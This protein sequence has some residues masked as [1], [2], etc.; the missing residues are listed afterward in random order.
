MIEIICITGKNNTGKTLISEYIE[1]HYKYYKINI[2]DAM[3]LILNDCFKMFYEYENDVSS[4]HYRSKEY[5]GF[6]INKY[7]AITNI[8]YIKNIN[9]F[10]NNLNYKNKYKCKTYRD[11]MIEFSDIV[12]KNTYNHIW[13]SIIDN[14]LQMLNKIGQSKFIIS[15]LR[16]IEEL[17]FLKS[18]YSIK[19]IGIN[20]EDNIPC[21]VVI[22][23]DKTKSQ[24]YL[25]EQI[26]NII[27]KKNNNNIII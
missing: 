2:A 23:N 5:S 8:K 6:S 11:Y 26:N 22:D 14:K 16:F 15:D 17:N 4:L 27:V 12:K 21:D 10:K 7:K 13:I 9:K 1:E 19:V 24:E 3:K 25:T 20:K 18:K